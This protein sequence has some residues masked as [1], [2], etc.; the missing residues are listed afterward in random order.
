M[1]RATLFKPA[2][3]E[4]LE[5]NPLWKEVFMHED[6][7]QDESSS[8]EED[9]FNMYNQTLAQKGI[10]ATGGRSQKNLMNMTNPV[11]K[12]S[13]GIKLPPIDAHR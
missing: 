7:D 4:N 11:K 10:K 2:K 3:K 8:G 5:K 9:A 6:S 1:P 13:E 12:K